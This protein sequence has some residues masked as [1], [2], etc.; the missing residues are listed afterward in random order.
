[1]NFVLLG[2]EDDRAVVEEAL[3]L[4]DSCRTDNEEATE[5][6]GNAR[7]VSVDP[8]AVGEGNTRVSEREAGPSKRPQATP[9][10]KK[11]RAKT[12][13]SSSTHQL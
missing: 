12:F 13:A 4:I 1:M 5:S 7:S 6:S 9:N 11:P 3:A 8:I 10:A 2:T